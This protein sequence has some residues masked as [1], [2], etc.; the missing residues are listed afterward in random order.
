MSKKEFTAYGKNAEIVKQM[1]VHDYKPYVDQLYATLGVPYIE[2]VKQAFEVVVSNQTGI[3]CTHIKFLDSD[4]GDTTK[5][6]YH[7][8]CFVRLNSTGPIYFY[9]PNGAVKNDSVLK[10]VVDG[11]FMTTN[12]LVATLKNGR[13]LVVRFGVHD[14]IQFFSTSSN[15]SMY[16]NGGGYCMFYIYIFMQS[17]IEFA[18]QNRDV[19]VVNSYVDWIINYRYSETDQGIFPTKRQISIRSKAIVDTAF[20]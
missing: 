18:K 12:Q 1:V 7:A 5:E 13:P 16:I 15:S 20:P 8:V 2:D 6:E 17:V 11:R 4:V 10:F 19:N 9:D 14:G 3:V